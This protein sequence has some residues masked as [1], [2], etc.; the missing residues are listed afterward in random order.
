MKSVGLV[1]GLS[2]AAG[3]VL[4]WYAVRRTLRARRSGTGKDVALPVPSDA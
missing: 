3:T 1:A 4:L 2:L